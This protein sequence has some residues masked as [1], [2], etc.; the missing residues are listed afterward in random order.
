MMFGPLTRSCMSAV[1]AGVNKCLNWCCAWDT[2]DLAA[3]MRFGETGASR[4]YPGSHVRPWVFGVEPDPGQ[5]GL[6]AKYPE[7]FAN[8]SGDT[9]AHS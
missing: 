1:R 2:K 3:C 4:F 7:S 5:A 8:V 6:L 9:Q